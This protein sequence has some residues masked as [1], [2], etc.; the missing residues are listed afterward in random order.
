MHSNIK[1]GVRLR[2]MGTSELESGAENVIQIGPGSVSTSVPSRTNQYN[3]DWTYNHTT[4]QLSLYEEMC[5]PLIESVFEGFNAT[6]L[7]CKSSTNLL[8]FTSITSFSINFTLQTVKPGAER[9]I[10]YGG[11]D[12]PVFYPRHLRQTR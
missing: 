9:H 5:Q 2:P 12:Y 7:A 10:R 1:V 4:S 11:W 8:S 6:F 3:F